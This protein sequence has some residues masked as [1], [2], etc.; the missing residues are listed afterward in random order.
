[1]YNRRQLFKMK[2]EDLIKILSAIIYQEAIIAENRKV[3]K[4]AF[5]LKVQHVVAIFQ[6]CLCM[7][8]KGDLRFTLA[9]FL[10]EV[11]K[12]EKVEMPEFWLNLDDIGFINPD[13]E[14][15]KKNDLID[16]IL[17]IQDEAQKSN[18][19]LIRYL[20]LFRD[21]DFTD[22]L[23]KVDNV[24]LYP[25]KKYKRYYNVTKKLFEEFNAFLEERDFV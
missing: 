10:Q 18:F 23:K 4:V 20:S 8:C 1:M 13:F 9:M 25:C 2:K 7:E 22:W 15:M 12:L 14:K 17:R 3:A 19:E 6:H 5:Q 21:A 11:R 16:E 24:I